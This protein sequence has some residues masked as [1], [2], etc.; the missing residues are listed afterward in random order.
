[1]S[2][3]TEV[4]FVG[5]HAESQ[6]ETAETQLPVDDR[7]AAI[8]AV[9]KAV[10][11]AAV[12]EG[13]S[14]VKEAED[15]DAKDQYKPKGA[16]VDA[17]AK[18]PKTGKFLP[19]DAKTEPPAEEPVDPDTANVKQVLKQREKLAQQKQKAQQEYQQHQMRMQQEYAEIQ[20]MRA[21]TENQR[22]QLE[23]LRKNPVKAIR[24]MGWD[25]EDLIVSLANEGTAEGKMAALIRQQQHQLE[26]INN[27]KRQQA[28]QAEQTKAQQ[29]QQQMSQYR[30]YIENKFIGHVGNEETFPHINAFYKGREASLIA[31]GDMVAA[32]YRELTGKEA[33]LEDIAEYIEE[34]L[35]ERSNAW[36][37]RNK[38]SKVNAPSVAGKPAR[39]SSGKTLTNTAASSRHSAGKDLRDLDGEDRL[40]AAKSSSSCSAFGI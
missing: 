33:S 24:D 6:T 3:N 37:E 14:A 12:E 30:N 29:Q 11:E 35:A 36:Y 5:G 38:S 22:K 4:T 13:K 8:A 7:E 25:P 34:T 17:P 20:R 18:D 27:W 9:K 21:E 40:E 31:E 19:K 2:E 26:E 1:M 39:G 32:Q 15:A 10:K 16:K 23:E 28:E